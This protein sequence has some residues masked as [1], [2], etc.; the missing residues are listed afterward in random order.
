MRPTTSSTWD[1]QAKTI[2][3]P[4]GNERQ[5]A[6]RRETVFAAKG[7]ILSPLLRPNVAPKSRGCQRAK[8]RK[9]A[10]QQEAQRRKAANRQEAGGPFRRLARFNSPP[11]ERAHLMIGRPIVSS[12]PLGAALSSGAAGLAAAVLSGGGPKQWRA[13]APSQSIGHWQRVQ[14]KVC[15]A[16]RGQ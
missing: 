14:S 2:T 13:S 1:L 4:N 15:A 9:G 8:R 3:T 6:A 7:P 10:K 16:A 12:W 11:S 5:S